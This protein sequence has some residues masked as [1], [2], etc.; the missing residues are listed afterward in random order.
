[1][2]LLPFFREGQVKEAFWGQS[3][4]R[5]SYD[6]KKR[7]RTAEIG[8]TMDTLAYDYQSKTFPYLVRFVPSHLHLYKKSIISPPM[9]PS[10][11]PQRCQLVEL[12][13]ID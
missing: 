2:N 11:S 7:L 8:S 13:P 1:M 9:C 4:Y 12:V 6:S 5:L 3:N 10:F